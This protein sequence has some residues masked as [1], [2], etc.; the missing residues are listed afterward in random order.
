MLIEKIIEELQEIPEDKLT[1][2]DRNYNHF[3]LKSSAF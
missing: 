2:V 3:D 1:V